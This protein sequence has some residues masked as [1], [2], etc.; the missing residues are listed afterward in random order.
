MRW[1]GIVLVLAQYSAALAQEEK[2]FPDTKKNHWAYEAITRF[3]AEGIL[4]FN[5]RF[6]QG[7]RLWARSEFATCVKL[8]STKLTS[9]FGQFDTLINNVNHKI[10]GLQS[11]TPP[12]DA[13]LKQLK[14]DLTDVLETGL[15][16]KT[17]HED[18]VDLQRLIK[19]FAPDITAQ[20]VDVKK[21]RADVRAMD[22]RARH[23]PNYKLPGA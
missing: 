6:A 19:E 4:M 9:I 1:L 18:I 17:Y 3:R 21:L 13:G 2:P 15:G 22:R 8:S 10:S 5:F 11:T 12:T 23:I 20:G 16:V 7:G 14:T